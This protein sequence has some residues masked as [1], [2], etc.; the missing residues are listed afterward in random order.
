MFG[1]T[2]LGHQGW[3]FQTERSCIL[4]DPLLCEE[5]GKIHSLGYKVFPPRVLTAESFPKLDAV[6]LSHEH[7]DHFD[8]PSLARLDRAIPIYLSSRSS[9]AA[10]GILKTM[11][12]EVRPLVPG[13]PVGFGDLELVPCCGD[14]VIASAGD[15]WDTLPYLVRDTNG[16]GNFFTMVDIPLTSAHLEWAKAHVPKPG[17]IGWTNNAMDWS[18]MAPHFAERTEGTQESLVKM[19]AGHKAI[20]ERWGTPAAMVMCAGGFAFTG[21]RAWLN[22]LVFCVDTHA[23]CNFMTARYKKELFASGVPGQTFWMEGGKLKQLDK[24]QPFLATE[25]AETWPSREKLPRRQL[26]DYAPA[27]G[28]TDADLGEL[29]RELDRLAGAVFGG[30]LFRSLCSMLPAEAPDRRLTFAIVA[31]HG[32]TAGVFEY[33]PT[34]CCFVPGEADARRVYLAGFECWASDL[35]AVLRGEVGP[36]ALTF[37]RS[38]VWNALPTR[39]AFGISEELYRTSHPLRRPAEYLK[40][41]EKAWQAVA[42]TQPVFG[43]AAR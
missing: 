17:V 33:V 27:T 21:E 30:G 7:D 40:V 24:A 13:V 10:R 8:I 31:R 2:F 5:F 22:D 23:V 20:V 11:G 19:S 12:F 18:H 29:A 42:D 25:P 14:H 4:V 37:G 43:H 16:H 41:Y 35:L 26:P 1:T 34:E 15:E 28:R 36:I 6:V 3:M 9:S 39:F 32:D 38:R